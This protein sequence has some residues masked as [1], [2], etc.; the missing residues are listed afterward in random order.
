MKKLFSF[1]MVLAMVTSLVAAPKVALPNKSA[2]KARTELTL[3]AVQ[4]QQPQVK[5]VAKKN[6]VRKAVNAATEIT[7]EQAL[8]IG[9]ALADNA[10]TD[11]LKYVSGSNTTIEI[12]QGTVE[13]LGG[14]V[15]PT[16]SGDVVIDGLVYVDA[17]FY[18]DDTY[19]D[20][21]VFDFYHDILE[22]NEEYYLG[23]PM[24]FF[25]CEE[26]TTSG[27]KIAGTWTPFESV[28]FATDD[29]EDEGVYTDEEEPEGSLQVTCVEQGVYNF[30]GSFVGEDGKT[31]TWTLNNIEVEAYNGTTYEDITLT[32][33]GTPTPPTALLKIMQNAKV[34]KMLKQGKV[35]ILRDNQIFDLS[36]MQIK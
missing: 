2:K 29:E 16:P 11:I 8:E 26:S 5:D 7:P 6:I 33:G 13:I 1:V 19:G 23:A 12:K 14:D 10:T 35:I 25:T 15:P 3:S 34:K 4:K 20:Y 22:I 36:G 28:Y 21:W 30:V 9:K 32:D 18:E 24:V 31:Y 27:T 17:V